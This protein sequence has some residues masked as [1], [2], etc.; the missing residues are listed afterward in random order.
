MTPERWRQIT[1]VF[2]AA[3]ARD[4]SARGPYLDEACAGDDDLRREVES[5][6]VQGASAERFLDR[7]AVAA[8]AQMV[9]DTGASLL[10]GRRIG[11][12]EVLA[13]LGAG[14]MGE[15]YR[16]RDTRLGREVA[17]KI[18]PRAFTSD[19]D[20]LARFEREA[21][22]LA[23][24]NHPHIGAIHGVEDGEGIHAL[25]LELVEG[26]TLADRIAARS[27][28][29]RVPRS[30]PAGVHVIE[31]LD[32]A[33]QIADALDAAHEKGII[34]RDLK[35][36]NIKITPEGVAKVLDFGLSKIAYG[37]DG[38]SSQS[39]TITVGGTREGVILGT[40]A[41]MSPEQARGL[42]VDK[43][44]D[45]WA[46][47]CVLYEMLTGRPA[48]ARDTVSDTLAA[49][50]EREPDWEALPAG[51]PPHVHRLLRR[52]LEK[53]PR[54][55]TRDIGDARLD[56]GD[57]PAIAMPAPPAARPARAARFW[58]GLAAGVAVG[59]ALAS[60]A[61]RRPPP[62]VRPLRLS[63]VA[64]QGTTFTKRDITEHPQF[65]LSPDGSR[66]AF[67]ASA[68]GE[69]SR[70]WV[71]SLESG[72][73]QPV[74]GTED[75][76]GPFWAPDG[77]NVAFFARGKLKKV[78][79]NGAAPLDLADITFDILNGTWSPEGLI[80]FPGG[81]G[82][83]LFRVPSD[84]GPV[85]AAT[86]LDASRGETAHRWPQFLPDGRRFIFLVNSAT[87]ANA[88]VYLGS[89]DSPSKTRIMASGSSAAYAAPGY[90]LFEQ[91]GA[92][93]RQRFDARAGTLSGQPEAL[94]DRI[95]GL[96]GPSYLPLSV[97]GNGTLAYWSG[98]L[99]PSE[100]L[101]FDRGGRPLGKVGAATRRDS[102]VLSPDGTKVLVSIRDNPNNNELWRFDL[103]SGV[104][105]RLTFTRG[106]ARFAIWSPDSQHIAFSAA[107]EDGPQ[108]FQK[109]ASGAGG[110]TRIEGPGRH[111][112]LFP[113]DWSRDGRSILYVVA[114]RT[115]FD[116]WAVHVTERKA[117]PILETR[118]N[119]VQPRLSPDGRWLAYTSDESG[120]WEVYV[121]GFKERRGKWLVSS[122]GG[123]Q[124]L[125]RG[126]GK[127]LFYA[128][129]DG[130]LFAVTVSG[131][132]TFEAGQ[133][134]PLFQTTLPPMLAPFRT[135]YAV[136]PDGQRFLLNSL[137]PN[138]EPPA[139]TIV[140]NSDADSKR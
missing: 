95:L 24:L 55:R 44:T 42:S 116:I 36:A 52:C 120:T 60:F 5:L 133:P 86:T 66:L 35:P 83:P 4:A 18:L 41:Y 131:D 113:D 22:I 92:L 106:V 20:R 130:R 111:Y 29:G 89:I 34:H 137:H 91:N 15:V 49:I 27:N 12:Y 140:F 102:P 114:G 23:A 75:A 14:G 136:S 87:P 48:F 1:E 76:S 119:E 68:P 123:S 126:D 21:R 16:A 103:A 53:D 65:A 110:E 104:S 70:V 25:V 97:A 26:E 37:T 7:G 33:R 108:L 139:I 56:L 79:L 96:R 117:E 3:L 50:L 98:S 122:A 112:A 32:I 71:R 62:N 40:A 99:T 101:W 13:P 77:Q 105:S 43:R 63:V 88:G 82:G 9:S 39:P 129:L 17:I 30:G 45:I 54:K 57:A 125:W 124:P 90:L 118:A 6:L 100:L 138:P 115:A 8:A 128:G 28:V 74:S 2:H 67:I 10:T 73:A 84:G 58:I 64:P 107:D 135:G 31:A 134:R 81:N 72:A 80:L 69:R 61:I 38:A 109:A 121:Q 46:F 59:A 11:V 94:G 51:T 132:Q 47:G 78:S 93:T 127:E 19:P 85:T